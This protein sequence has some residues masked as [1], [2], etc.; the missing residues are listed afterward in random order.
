MKEILDLSIDAMLDPPNS[1]PQHR[2][3]K[4]VFADKLLVGALR[5]SYAALDIECTYL[6]ESEG[7]DGCIS[8]LSGHLV[9]KDMAS[10]GSVSEKPGLAS[11]GLSPEQL[12][13]WH[14]A[15]AKFGNLKPWTKLMER[16]AI[17]IDA[18]SSLALNTKSNS[19]VKSF[20]YAIV[21]FLDDVTYTIC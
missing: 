11:L 21:Y 2:P 17:Q 20:D 18:T 13:A 9:R 16:Q 19:S 4:V 15:C 14:E 5:K 10:I 7:I 3:E 12:K 8:E 6:T 1:I